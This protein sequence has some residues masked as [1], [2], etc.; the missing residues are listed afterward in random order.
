MNC[1]FK[2]FFHLSILMRLPMQGLS[3]VFVGFQYVSIN[4]FWVNR[5]GQNSMSWA[6]S[7]L[8][9]NS[10]FLSA[11]IFWLYN[12]FLIFFLYQFAAFMLVLCCLLIQ[13]VESSAHG[14]EYDGVIFSQLVW[15]GPFI[16]Q[17]IR[18]Y[19]SLAVLSCSH[20]FRFCCRIWLI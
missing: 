18:I 16:D 20:I 17:R 19:S 2:I 7:W 4:A 3:M 10:T 6:K 11:V 15:I 1:Y 12:V 8:G 9:Q 13:M 5:F 14:D